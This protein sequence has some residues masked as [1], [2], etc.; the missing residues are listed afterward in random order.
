MKKSKV[1]RTFET[2]S[3]QNPYLEEF[4]S[5]Q[6]RFPSYV[7]EREY[8]NE[9]ESQIQESEYFTVK[10]RI[11]MT[12]KIRRIFLQTMID[13]VYRK[14]IALINLAE[15]MILENLMSE[16]LEKDQPKSE[17]DEKSKNYYEEL[18]GTCLFILQH[19][20]LKTKLETPEPEISM[21]QAREAIKDLKD[22][23]ISDDRTYASRRQFYFPQGLVQITVEVPLLKEEK[24]NSVPY[25]SYTKG[26]GESGK[27]KISTPVDWEI[28][29]EEVYDFENSQCFQPRQLSIPPEE[30]NNSTEKFDY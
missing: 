28:D 5:F 3:L 2:S 10:W 6:V 18:I 4:E 8:D 14:T 26:Y 20:K 9:I 19:F 21:E 30:K 7:I 15:Y 25:S 11:T 29:G 1:R 27:R 22:F 24:R 13:S 12:R 17:K 16:I 23:S